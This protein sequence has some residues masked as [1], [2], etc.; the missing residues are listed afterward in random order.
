MQTQP[1]ANV[2]FALAH[3]LI[4]ALRQPWL[5]DFAKAYSEWQVS[6]AS[7]KAQ[8]SDILKMWLTKIARDKLP[9]DLSH[10]TL[11]IQLLNVAQRRGRNPSEF[12]QHLRSTPRRRASTG[13]DADE[14]W[15]D[16][17][18]GLSRAPN[19]R[20]IITAWSTLLPLYRQCLDLIRVDGSD[21]PASMTTPEDYAWL[22]RAAQLPPLPDHVLLKS[23]RDLSRN[24]SE[25]LA[26]MLVSQ[27]TLWQSTS[28]ILL[29]GCGHS[30]S[31]FIPNRLARF[32]SFH[33]PLESATLDRARKL[34][35]TYPPGILRT[36]V[37]SEVG[38]L[39]SADYLENGLTLVDRNPQATGSSHA[40]VAG[41]GD[42]L[43]VGNGVNPLLVLLDVDLKSPE[44]AFLRLKG[45][46]L[47]VCDWASQMD[48]VCYTKVDTAGKVELLAD[49]DPPP[50]DEIF[51]GP[52]PGLVPERPLISPFE[53]MRDSGYLGESNRVG[54][55]PNW[56][57][58]P[59]VPPSP[60]D[61]SPMTFLAQFPH[62]T[63]GTAY[64]FLDYRHLVAA[65]V[66][67]WD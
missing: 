37:E 33:A 13:L 10:E 34:N 31:Y 26:S 14:W 48:E 67:Q 41:H 50:V 63:G 65:V 40:A 54:G 29:P 47:R 12:F 5:R 57:Q 59:E 66:T 46:R 11:T 38:D 9:E 6:A 23:F 3:D 25:S 62:P 43:H 60:I 20:L 18:L 22:D 15:D 42:L 52:Y 7:D 27:Q 44:M 61:S 19:W 39:T 49:C 45:I 24:T 16:V 1:E 55:A 64:I 53:G 28:V 36:H 2:Q 17:D 8:V 21:T 32:A 58:Y 30:L 56:E 4:C 51:R 35:I